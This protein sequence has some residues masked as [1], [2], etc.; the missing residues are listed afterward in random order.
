[1]A[2]SRFVGPP[3]ITRRRLFVDTQA[4]GGCCVSP[5]QQRQAGYFQRSSKR[6][7]REAQESFEKSEYDRVVRKAQE[8]IE[9]YLK[10]RLVNKGIEPAK[11]HDLASLAQGLGEKLQVSTEELDFLTQERIPAFY[12]A[13][14]FVP[15]ESYDNADGERC[16]A[17][18]K[19]LKLL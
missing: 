1:M 19:S 5:T 6:I 13:S 8:S 9:L 12:G 3:T 15:D 11:V 2:P 16:V 18:L 4:S 10:G 17:M 14:D 7:A